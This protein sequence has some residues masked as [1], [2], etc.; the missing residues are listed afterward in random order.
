MNTQS[1]QTFFHTHVNDDGSRQMI[2]TTITTIVMEMPRR[3]DEDGTTT[4]PSPSV[5]DDDI[6]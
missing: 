3:E 1:T 4:D 6:F 2:Q 5:E